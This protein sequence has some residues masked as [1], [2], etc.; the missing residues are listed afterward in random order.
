VL[1]KLLEAATKTKSLKKA[2]VSSEELPIWEAHGFSN[3]G[4]TKGRY[5]EVKYG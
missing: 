1:A 2:I 4:K 5:F 3:T